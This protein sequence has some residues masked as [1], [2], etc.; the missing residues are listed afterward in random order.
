MTDNEWFMPSI[1]FSISTLIGYGLYLLW[2]YAGLNPNGDAAQAA[3]VT[4]FPAMGIPY[5]LVGV[6]FFSSLGEF[7]RIIWERY[8]GNNNS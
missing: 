5:L 4:I 3:V 8:R 2:H 6:G 7:G 1:V